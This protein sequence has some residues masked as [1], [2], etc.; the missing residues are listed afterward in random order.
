LVL[1]LLRLLPRKALSHFTGIVVHLESP[2]WFANFLKHQL[3]KALKIDS[4]EAE[5][6][7]DEYKSFGNFFS[8]RLKEGARPVSN[9]LLISPCDGAISQQGIID[10]GLLTQSKN[11]NY[12]LSKLLKN[13]KYVDMFMSG[14][15][16]T[17]YLAPFNYHRVHV[18]MNG[19][20]VDNYTIAGD[21]WP[22]NQKS[23]ESIDELFCINERNISI[24]NTTEG[25]YALLMIGATNVGSIELMENTK[26]SSS[27]NKGDE[28][29]IFNMGS[30]VV[31]LFDRN[32]NKS[33]KID[34]TKLGPTKCSQSLF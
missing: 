7:I 32:I 14:Y 18:P 28:Y 23:V 34:Q 8:R 22:V 2:K 10:N 9:S 15:F 26:V 27:L 25:Y 31:L 13:D 21:L 33:L 11:I 1:T 12:S 3:I 17:I 5:K 29:G 16:V 20:I 24:F 6:H 30:T 4:S 19:D